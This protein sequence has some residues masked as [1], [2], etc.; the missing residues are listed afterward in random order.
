M[1]K[2]F[3]S[4]D[5][6]STLDGLLPK[7]RRPRRTDPLSKNAGPAKENNAKVVAKDEGQSRRGDKKTSAY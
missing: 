7:F 4:P 6:C 1:N 2:R 3:E 5:F